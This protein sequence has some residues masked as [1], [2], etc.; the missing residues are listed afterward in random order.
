MRSGFFLL[1]SSVL[2]IP[3]LAGNGYGPWDE[4]RSRHSGL[5]A[6][7]N[8]VPGGNPTLKSADKTKIWSGDLA[9]GYIM[10]EGNTSD[11]SLKFHSDIQRNKGNWHYDFIT[12]ATNTKSEGDRSA[13]RYFMSHRGAYDFSPTN[14]VFG[15]L[16]YDSDRFSGFRYKG[17]VA[18]GFGRRLINRDNMKWD[19]EGGP[20]YRRTEVTADAVGEDDTEEGIVRLATNFEWALSSNATFEQ[21]ASVETGDANTSARSVTAL[22]TTVVGNLGMKLSYTVKYTDDVPEGRE[23]AD[24]ETAITLVYGF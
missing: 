22:K 1:L 2:S 24:T 11:K 9:F 15:F 18:L 12:D 10:T 21:E 19:I 23:H 20:G 5:L 16:S 3:A 8:D 13:E 14:Y 7:L 6:A 4:D 17:T